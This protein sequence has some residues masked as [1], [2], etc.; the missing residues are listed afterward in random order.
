MGKVI[1]MSTQPQPSPP[2]PVGS[3]APSLAPGPI[4]PSD[5]RN[6]S[7]AVDIYQKL[8]GLTEAVSNLKDATKSNIEKVEQIS[9]WVFAIPNLEKAVAQ[10]TKDL[11]EVGKR[12]DKDIKELEK[13]AHTAR[14][15]GKIALVLATPVA[16]AII[17][18][19]L[20][21]IYRLVE[22]LLFPR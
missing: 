17:I 3:E 20:I 5:I 9:Q 11:N 2:L 22:R 16:V 6:L 18:P 7:A 15:L 10:N 1:I 8:G 19:V 14:R 4:M 12:H 21:S 13:V